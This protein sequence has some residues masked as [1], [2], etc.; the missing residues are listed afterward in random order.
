MRLV[1]DMDWE[2]ITNGSE[3]AAFGHPFS[4]NGPRYYR[5]V[6]GDGL[7]DLSF[8]FADR[9][10]PAAVVRCNSFSA[11][12]LTCYGFP[13]EIWVRRGLLP[14][15]HRML[16]NLA[17]GAMKTTARDAALPDIILR[18][19]SDPDFAAAL[20]ARLIA[21][22]ARARP[23]FQAELDLGQSDEAL[24]AAMN[25]GHRQRVRWGEANLTL[26]DVDQ[27]NPDAAL[28]AQY[29]AL[30]AQVA[31]RVTRRQQSWDVMFELIAAGHGGLILAH[32]GGELIGGAFTM[33]AD[34]RAYY[35]SAAYRRDH[36]DKPLSHYPVYTSALR[37]RARGN[38]TYVLGE[39]GLSEDDADEK[40]RNIGKFKAGFSSTVATGIV[41]TL[42]VSA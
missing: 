2:A 14:T 19:H 21:M 15:D 10:G 32:H 41:W 38:R 7:K 9:L 20:T 31:G 30:H 40:E 4:A 25:S 28:F 42:A 39:V 3:F 1:K 33:D 12:A 8:G 35:A 17:L 13:L 18:N 26:I 36:F 23:R 11:N 5:A 16:A 27:S 22:E 24:T 34:G 6:A 37:A 29:Q